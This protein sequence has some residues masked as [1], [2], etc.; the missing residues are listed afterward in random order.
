MRWSCLMKAFPPI[1]VDF[2]SKEDKVEVTVIGKESLIELY[3]SSSI[4]YR[5][6]LREELGTMLLTEMQK[7]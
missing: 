3:N 1:F 6:L 7:K 2:D 5:K 4:E